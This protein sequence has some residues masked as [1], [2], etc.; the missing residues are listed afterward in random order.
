MKATH[1]LVFGVIS[2]FLL[3][4]KER[5]PELDINNNPVN[6]EL[7]GES[8]ISSAFYERDIAITPDG[9]E[10]IFTLSDYKQKRRC[11]VSIKNQGASWSKPEILNITGTHQDIEPFLTNNGTRLYFASDRPA[12][13]DTS[14]KD[15]NLWYS[16][17]NENIWSE[18]VFL[19]TII[20]SSKDEF[21]PSLS[22]NG[23]L[24]F[25][26]TK[27][28]GIGR[29]DIYFSR[30]ENGTYL[31]PEVLDTNINSPSYEFNAFISPDENL[32]V[33]SSFGRKD[34]LGGGDLYFS[35]KDE[36]G[37]WH[38]A[39]NIGEKINSEALDYCPFIDYERNNFYF[40]SE[41]TDLSKQFNNINELKSFSNKAGNGL[42]DIYRISLDQL[43]I[44]K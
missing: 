24:Y 30:N 20:N 32:L 33:F 14:R 11:L 41:R 16:E 31:K 26:A 39:R 13:G 3:S 5:V 42:G 19:D 12:P 44:N 38:K 18:P 23:N 21:Y 27:K 8:I 22:S 1:F 37:K 35:T 6:L 15:Y 2:F 29:E 4:C 40:S 7:F 43:D 10:I 36:E 28:D 34:G 17:R 25:T 9:K